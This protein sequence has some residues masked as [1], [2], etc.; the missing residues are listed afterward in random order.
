M[1]GGYV[2]IIQTESGPVKIGIAIDAMHRLATHQISNHELLTLLYS[3]ECATYEGAE[4]IESAL[5]TR[6]A[7]QHIRGEWFAIDPENIIR[8]IEFFC[9]LCEVVNGVA[10]E[11]IQVS[12]PAKAPKKPRVKL[13]EVARQIHEA[14]DTDLSV[15]EMMRK[16][17]ISQG[18]TSKIR[19]ILRQQHGKGYTNG[20]G[21]GIAQ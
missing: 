19:D 20:L 9:A 7:A 14:G 15:D 12:K 13:H 11:Y 18:S 4:R 17:G 10:V 21:G 16:Y 3:F 8:D 2:Y 5:K 6:Y 1:N